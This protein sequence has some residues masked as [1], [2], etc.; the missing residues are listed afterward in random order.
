MTRK[1][2]IPYLQAI[3]EDTLANGTVTVLRD[4][5]ER[6]RAELGRQRAIRE[7]DILLS[8]FRAVLD[9]IEYGIL[10]LDPELRTRAVNRAFSEMW[11]LPDE[12]TAR[13]PT[14]ADLINYNRDTGLYVESNVPVDEWEGYVEEQVQAVQKGQVPPTELRRGDGRILRYEGMAL[15]GGGRMMTYFDITDLV[16]RSEYLAALHETTL[17]LITRLDLNDLL[18]DLVSRA[19]QLIGAPHG[20]IYL[21]E[22]FE[23]AQDR[24]DDAVSRVLECKVGVGVF[25]QTIDFRLKRGEGLAG[26]I[27][28][29]RQPLVIGNYDAWEGRS[30]HFEYGA[31]GAVVGAPLESGSQV[32]GVIG[33]AYDCESGRTFG[34]EEVDLLGRF[35]ELASVAL[36]NARLYTA[37]QQAREAAEAAT[38]AKSAF[39]ATMSHEI[40]T[41][42]NAVIGMTS[43]LLDTDLTPDQ[44]EFVETVRTSGDAL[45][46]IINDILDFSKIEA[47][48]MDLENQPFDLREC[49]ESAL[50]LV[51]AKAFEKGLDLAYL[52]DEQVPTAIF[53]DVTRLRQVLVN[54][55]SNGVK[56]TERGEIIVQVTGHV[57]STEPDVYELYFA[58]RDT[59][60]GIPPD[61]M[62]RLFQ[63]FSQ[64][65]ASTTRRYGGTGLGLV[66]S[67]RLSELMGGT[68]WVE[69]EVD[70]GSTFYFTIRAEVAPG[71]ELPYLERAQPNLDGKRVLIVDDN[72]TN[73]RILTFQT[74]AWGMLPRDADSPIE[75]LEWIRSGDPFDVVML[76]MQMPEM[77]GLTLATEIRRHESDKPLLRSPLPL[78]MLSSLSQRETSIEDQDLFAAYLTK[79]IKASQLYNVVVGIFA[80]EAQ[81]ETDA[82][83]AREE[84]SQFDAQ[85]AK[86]LPLRILLAE[87]N[88]VNQKLALRLLERMGYRA[89]VAGNGVEALEALRRQAYDVVLMDVQMPEMDGLEATRT[90][91]REWD[92]QQ[93]PHIIAMTANAMKEDRESCLNAG[94][95]DYVSKPIRVNELVD[96]LA[97][98]KPL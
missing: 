14:L 64:V 79:P 26:K 39:L 28:Q 45:L 44:Q 3:L 90:I 29:T 19:G 65:D 60:I 30:P 31:V 46:T 87:D 98:C 96:A 93:G 76:D 5:T 22:P 20:F 12:F 41:P 86:R 94:M 63:S 50:D 51:T 18:Q 84:T 75:A 59:G 62:E 55:L 17:G 71:P 6:R 67:K 83:E 1:E 27:W 97:K 24:P 15:P 80:Q 66:I 8:E 58:V 92:R 2:A 85:M 9:A 95:D 91:R 47:G 48:K 13:Q 78:V 89:D 73:R 11:A 37:V 4:V 81:P 42:M 68:M 32:V 57:Q 70:R 53:G 88:A 33:M 25:A 56:F 23:S 10:L 21:V 74:R 35:A 61:R 16:H 34:D 36:D 43:L 38:R 69:S 72:A 82:E 52:V 7:K 77:D 54:L 49:V 40:R